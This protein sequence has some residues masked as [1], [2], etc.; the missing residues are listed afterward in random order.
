MQRHG[1]D[2]HLCVYALEATKV[3]VVLAHANVV[4]LIAP[5]VI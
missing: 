4:D 3:K 1:V 2:I 5:P